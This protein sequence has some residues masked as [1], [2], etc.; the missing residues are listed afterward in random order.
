MKFKKWL[1]NWDLTN[2]KV[3]V[4]ILNAEWKPQEKDR[5][6]AWELYVEML[7][8]VV[9]QPLSAEGGDESGALESLHALF[10]VTREVLRRKGR[11]CVEFTKIAVIVLNQVVRPFTTRWHQK[12]LAGELKNTTGKKQFRDELAALQVVLRN[13]TSALAG[14]AQVE[15]LSHLEGPGKAKE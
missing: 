2:L 5:E 6:A 3:N 7:T 9:T 15:D 10:G 12:M 1:E 13:Y 4:G 8:R 14:I 11:E